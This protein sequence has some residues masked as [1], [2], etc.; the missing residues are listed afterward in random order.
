MFYWSILWRSFYDRMIFPAFVLEEKTSV[1]K[2]IAVISLLAV[3]CSSVRML[4]FMNFLSNIPVQMALENVPEI[5][6][7]DKGITTPENF[8]YAYNQRD[9]FFV[10][11][12]TNSEVQVPDFGYGVFLGKDHFIYTSLN[13]EPYFNKHKVDMIY[14]GS[15]SEQYQDVVVEKLSKYKDKLLKCIEDNVIVLF[16]GMASEIVGN[17]ILDGDKKIETLGLFD[18]YFLRDK[19]K[20]HNSL[21]IGKFNNYKIVGN[22]SQFTF[23]YENK[24][25]FIKAYP[26]CIGDNPDSSN[27]GIHYKNCFITS[28]VNGFV[29]V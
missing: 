16:T 6:L 14:L 18:V 29:V 3:L 19:K 28:S 9:Y 2:L 26:K 27:E 5:V 17:Y 25:S 13:D 15:I 24:Y 23:M 22:K 21:F 20:R 4:G 1:K 8:Q 12:T 7:E 11:D 10:I